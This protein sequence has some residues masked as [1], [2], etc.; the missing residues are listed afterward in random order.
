MTRFLRRVAFAL[1]M[2]FALWGTRGAW[3]DALVVIEARGG[4]YHPGQTIADGTVPI[5]LKDGEQLVLVASSGQIVRLRGPRQTADVAGALNS[6]MTQKMARTDKA[7]VVRS[8]NTMLVPPDP[9]LMD[10]THSG[11]RCQLPDHPLTF[12]R[13]ESSTAATL[14]LMP[15]DR[16]WVAELPMKVGADR[17]DVPINVPVPQRAGFIVRIDGKDIALTVL[18]VP[19]ALQNDMMRVAWMSEMG[20]DGQALSLLHQSPTASQP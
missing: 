4:T 16:S 12:W 7:G 1:A 9:W 14:T 18:A 2:G 8:Q 17:V 10:A 5:P 6:L 20:C 13:P 15:V 3:A 19:A 11:R